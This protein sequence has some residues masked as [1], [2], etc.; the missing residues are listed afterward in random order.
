[1]LARR[2]NGSQ[3]RLEIANTREM[4]LERGGGPIH[5]PG[6]IHRRPIVIAVFTLQAKQLAERTMRADSAVADRHVDSDAIAV[7]LL[8]RGT[9]GFVI[10]VAISNT[11]TP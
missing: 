9:P 11:R 6:Q 4:L 5:L 7:Q 10:R 8:S 1:M 3:A 2:A